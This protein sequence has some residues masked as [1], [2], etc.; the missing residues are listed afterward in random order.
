MSARRAHNPTVTPRGEV[1][2]A[3]SENRP[4]TSDRFGAARALPA[5]RSAGWSR[6]PGGYGSQVTNASKYLATYLNDHLAGSTS[7]LELVRRA[8]SENKD[9]DLGAF[10]SGLTKE[11]EHDRETLKELMA[12]LGVGED[13]LKVAAG[14]LLE[15]IGRLKPN[16]QLTG[17]SPLSPLVELEGLELGI[18]G[19]LAMWRALLEVAGPPPLDAARLQDL[20]A[21]AER[22]IADVARHRLEVSRTALAPR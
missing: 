13:R 16:A 18:Q 14:W 12:A 9:N 5:A 6:R 19:K 15:K 3:I 4:L 20:A 1:S 7:G 8:A 11:I 17:Y 21:R 2:A 22:Q 10:L